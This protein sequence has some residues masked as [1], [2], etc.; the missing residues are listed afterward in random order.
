MS[1]AGREQPVVD[2]G[3]PEVP[4]EVAE[5]PD[6]TTEAIMQKDPTLESSGDEGADKSGGEK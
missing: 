6:T 2:P 3:V 4:K 1:D 5:A